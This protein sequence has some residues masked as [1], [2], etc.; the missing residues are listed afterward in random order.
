MAIEDLK[1]QFS[2]PN[3]VAYLNTASFSPAFK[4]V[5]DAGIKAVQL[6]SRPD[7]YQNSDLFEPVTKL[8]QLFANV[9]GADD[10]NRIVT[11]PSVSYGT[12]TVANN[13]TLQKGDE[14]LLIEE[15]FPSNVYTWRA[16]A[17]TFDANIVTIKQPKTIAD[18]NSEIL[19]AINDKTAVVA[20]AHIHWANGYIFDLKAI[21]S[22]T[23]QHNALMIIDGSQSI[24]AF[25]FSIKDI[26]PD[27]L[28][29]AGYKWLFGPYGCAYAYYSD[30]FDNGSPIEQ[31][32][33][34]RLNS[35]NLA[36]LTKYQ[37]AYK[38]LAQRYN[39][40]ESASF[41]YVKMQTAALKEILKIAPKELQDYCDSIS[42]D[43]LEDLNALG[44][45]SDDSEIR[46]KHLFGI[47][48]PEIVDLEKLKHQ[49]KSDNVIVSYRGDYIRIS[50]H[51]FNTRI[52]FNKLVE[53]ITKV[54][55]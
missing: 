42:K 29:C 4:S 35:E 26:Q 21:R 41:I 50:C 30:Y 17:K 31:N 38:P 48:I 53:S 10:H 20:M 14:I 12:A 46:A 7:F 24:G 32:W 49:L 13:I 16:L 40:G 23:K 8:R 55:S 19:K 45:I 15:Q 28:I 34:I 11:I 43:A 52:H 1:D 54:V 37:T 33:T 6:K 2:F 36:G 47:K 44:F 27:A 39:A 3:D 9:I 51:V 25:P 22:K 5:E 18:W